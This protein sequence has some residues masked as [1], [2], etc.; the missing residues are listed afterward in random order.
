M[1]I[2]KHWLQ[3]HEGGNI[4]IGGTA[5]DR[6][7]LKKLD[8]E[9]VIKELG[10]SLK[11]ISDRFSSVHGLPL[12]GDDLF[13]SRDFLSGSSLHLFD[14]SIPDTTFIQHK[15]TVGDI[16]TQVD[17]NLKSQIED[18][19]KSLKQGSKVGNAIYVGYKSSGDQFI[20]LWTIPKLDISVQVDLELV[21]F[22]NGK[23]TPWATFSHSSPWK[24]MSQGI[25]GVFQK[26]IM[27]S[28]QHRVAR[29]VIIQ[30]KTAKGK[31]KIIHSSDLA[32]SLKGI[33]YKIKPV[34][35]TQGNQVIKNGMYV[36]QELDSKG[37][38]YITDLDLIF[39]MSFGKNALFGDIE[40]MSSFVGIVEIINRYF[41][42]SDKGKIVDAFVNLLWDKGA[43]GLTRGDPRSDYDSKIKAFD[44][45]T[46][47]LGVGSLDQFQDKIDSYYKS[48]S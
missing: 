11:A 24:D 41:N 23:P 34:L 2:F 42:N 46:K 20:T 47:E 37:A 27:R 30:P 38:E 7:D 21:D 18:F 5:A 12:W 28:L 10:T 22:Q 16:D 13:K 8:R 26:Y 31:E 48:Y 43:Q 9:L 32:F 4:V 44:Y 25:K 17:G 39:K 15:P 19:L 3:L 40:K 29:D 36:Y 6:I 1:L 33:R 14:T 35:D 45:L